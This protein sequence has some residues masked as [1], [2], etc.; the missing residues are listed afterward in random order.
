MSKIIHFDNAGRAGIL[1]G[2]RKLAKSV[3]S[4]LGPYGKNVIIKKEYN[5]PHIT[6]DGVTVADHI[7]FKDQLEDIGAL[8]VRHAARKTAENSGDGT[9][10]TTIMAHKIIEQSMSAKLPI[11]RKLRDDIETITND[12]IKFI[13]QNKILFSDKNEM[14]YKVSMVAS[15]GDKVISDALADVYKNLGEDADVIADISPNF[16]TT[17]EVFDGMHFEGGYKAKEFITDPERDMCILKDVALVITDMKINNSEDIEDTVRKL[18]AAKKS[19][20]LIAPEIGGEAMYTLTRTAVQNPGKLCV[21]KSPGMNVRRSE[22]LEDIAV[23]TGGMVIKG[24]VHPSVDEAIAD[25]KFTGTVGLADK[26]I[27]RRGST[28][29]MSGKFDQKTLDSRIAYLKELLKTEKHKIMQDR[30]RKRISGLTSG[31]GVIY[32]GGASEVEVQEKRDRLDDCICAVKSALEMG[33]THGGGHIFHNFAET[34]GDK[35]PNID[36]TVLQI[37]L[38]A[39]RLPKNQIWVINGEREAPTHYVEYLMSNDIIDPIKVLID[40]IQNATSVAY[41]ILSTNA[42]VIND[43]ESQ[44]LLG[45]L[46]SFG[47]DE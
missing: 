8:L 15:N 7:R 37:L 2:A 45:D 21:I 47:E 34:Q 11:I 3:G 6:K 10:T 4:T 25:L 39:L 42:V 24:S 19:V 44:E 23:F 26:I 38:D 30:F 29:I 1:E 17:H 22:M 9:T 31:V 33:V 32:V 28:T 16:D 35:Y 18:L 43:K 46:P 40:E 5:D 36:P 27:I 12:V 41:S 13:K 14:I 20:L